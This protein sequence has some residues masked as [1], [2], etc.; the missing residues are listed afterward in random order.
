MVNI[1]TIDVEDYPAL[2]FRD[3]LGRDVGVSDRVDHATRD[4]LDILEGKVAS[5]TFFCLGSVAKAYPELIREIRRRGHEVASHGLEHIPF[6]RMTLA[7]IREDIGTAKSILEDILGEPVRGFRAPHFSIGL[8][9]PEVFEFLREAG[10]SYD[11]SIF[12][13]SG[14]RYG[15]A[16]SPCRPYRIETPS[17]PLLEY[18]LAT[19]T[20][21]GRRF[22][23]GGGGYLRHFPNRWNRWAIRKLNREG[24]TAVVYFHPYECDLVPLEYPRAGLTSARRIRAAFFNAHQY[25]GRRAMAGKIDSLVDDFVFTSICAN[26]ESCP[27]FVEYKPEVVGYPCEQLR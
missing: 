23:V 13:F 9:R 27:H 14:R 10:Y 1:L 7:E 25:H 11:S 12:P 24:I 26:I 3:F 16:A 2:F 4:V 5:A 17:G 6:Q 18:P 8:D 21:C 22:P 15:S 19:L 20:F